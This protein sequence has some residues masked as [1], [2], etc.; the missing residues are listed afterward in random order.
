MP[1][2]F[3]GCLLLGFVAACGDTVPTIARFEVDRPL[4]AAGETVTVTWETDGVSVDLTDDQ[5][6]PLRLVGPPS[7]SAEVFVARTTALRLIARGDAA[8]TEAS[9]GVSA[10]PVAEMDAL[11]RRYAPNSTDFIVRWATLG[12]T[13]WAIELGGAPVDGFAGQER[14]EFTGTANGAGDVRIEL[15]ARSND[16]S[17]SAAATVSVLA[18]EIEPNDGPAT[19]QPIAR[20]AVGEVTLG[21]VDLF[22]IEVPAGGHVRASLRD[23]EDGCDVRGTLRLLDANGRRVA[24]Q[25]GSIAC[26]ELSSEHTPGNRDLAAGT[27]LVAVSSVTAQSYALIVEAVEPACGNGIVESR[28]MELCEPGLDAACANDCTVDVTREVEPNDM[29]RDAQA[30]EVGALVAGQ[31]DNPGDRDFDW[32]GFELDAPTAVHVRVTG[33][34][35]TGCQFALD[36]VS[37]RSSTGAILKNAPIDQTGRWCG[38]IDSE[39]LPAGRYLVQVNLVD[40]LGPDVPRYF[41]R[42]DAGA[43]PTCGD[44]EV[45]GTETCDDGNVTPG[46]GCDAQC[47]FE[48]AQ[49][50]TP[51]AEPYTIRGGPLEAGEALVLEL[52]VDGPAGLVFDTFVPDVGRCEGD[53]DLRVRLDGTVIADDFGVGGC[54]AGDFFV[55]ASGPEVH[56]LRIEPIDGGR[57]D[58]FTM[59][60]RLFESGSVCG[61]LFL[62]P[63]TESCD[64]GNTAD[65]DGCDATCRVQPETAPVIDAPTTLTIDLDGRGQ[66]VAYPLTMAVADTRVI[67]TPQAGPDGFCADAFDVTVH[68]AGFAYVGGNIIN[69]GGNCN[70]ARARAREAG[71]HYLAVRNDSRRPIVGLRLDVEFEPPICGDGVFTAPRGEACDDGNTAVGDGCDAVCAVEAGYLVEAEP[72]DEI[73]TATPLLVR[74]STLAIDDVTLA[75]H[76]REGDETDF[77][78]LENASGAPMW[79]DV[80]IEELGECGDAH[81]LRLFDDTG[82][83]VAE[84]PLGQLVQCQ[85]LSPVGMPKVAALPPGRYTLEVARRGQA[86]STFYVNVRAGSG[87][88]P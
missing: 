45:Q 61:D 9:V 18:G 50:L 82:A 21:E 55:E 25:G 49:T 4:V 75:A 80:T 40:F 15:I 65:G 62:D 58:A 12:A 13:A 63:N 39:V 60:V 56:R 37:L 2:R 70:V 31:V 38:R 1:V 86:L 36:G 46:D 64:D 20:G 33:P 52:D 11:V 77:F 66:S 74:T 84:D 7:G 34:G 14:G 68:D 6:R 57:L 30:I 83:L 53:A 69:Q 3:R 5:S 73:A 32:Y 29:S 78:V 23:R 28:A 85:R 71:P 54:A 87:V 26:P 43:P 51:R 81:E 88:F 22:A 24:V 67:I 41:L 19:A 17:T 76:Q 72:N 79:I 44:G 48:V 27:Y 59:I 35:L 8:D 10:T 16:L 47:A 42:V